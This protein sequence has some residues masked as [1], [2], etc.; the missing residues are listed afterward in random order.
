[1]REFAQ[2]HKIRSQ[3]SSLHLSDSTVWH[4]TVQHH[5]L[6]TACHWEGI[7]SLSAHA[8]LPLE[9]LQQ[10][11]TNTCVLIQSQLTTETQSW[12]GSQEVSPEW[13][14]EI[15]FWA[16]VRTDHKALHYCRLKTKDKGQ[17]EGHQGAYLGIMS[18]IKV[19]RKE[20]PDRGK[21]HQTPSQDWIQRQACMGRISSWNAFKHLQMTQGY[22]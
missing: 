11:F 19:C 21:E 7:H 14:W 8:R 10:T 5:S 3:E 20:I 2:G 13:S 16:G 15:G 22:W 1:M 18:Q 4:I 12:R 9:T 6:Q 17:I